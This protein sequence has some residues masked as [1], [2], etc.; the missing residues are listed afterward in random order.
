MS[1]ATRKV[2]RMVRL[3]PVKTCERCHRRYKQRVWMPFRDGRLYC[4]Y[5]CEYCGNPTGPQEK[6]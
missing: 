4:K 3:I 6:K 1:D 2:R 5:V